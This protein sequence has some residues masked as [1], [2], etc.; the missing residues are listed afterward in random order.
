MSARANTGEYDLAKN[1]H[2]WATPRPGERSE[3]S[4][5]VLWRDVLWH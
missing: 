1:G 5:S 2:Q 3:N 4:D